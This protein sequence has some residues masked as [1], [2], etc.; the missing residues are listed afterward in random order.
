LEVDLDF[1]DSQERDE[2]LHRQ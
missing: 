1:L 2:S